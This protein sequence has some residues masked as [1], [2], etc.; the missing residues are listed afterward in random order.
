MK[1]LKQTSRAKL[2]L[3]AALVFAMSLSTPLMESSMG[4]TANLAAANGARLQAWFIPLVGVL[5]TGKCEGGTCCIL[6]PF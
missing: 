1:P 3:T 5:C 6:T 4:H 2:L